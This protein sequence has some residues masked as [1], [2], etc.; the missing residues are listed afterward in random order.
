M[1]SYHK[2]STAG[3]LWRLASAAALAA[4]GSVAGAQTPTRPSD[5]TTTSLG[6]VVISATR[7]TTTLERVPL[8]ATVITQADIKKSPAQ[9]L[10]QL[11]RDIPGMNLP[12]A[13]FYTT[14]PTGQQTKLRGVTNSKVLVLVD[15]VP[16]HDPFYSTTQWFKVPLSSIERVEVIRG[17]S[18]SLWGN[19]A[20]A[21]V[22]NI[23]TRKPIDNGGQV[24]VNYQS[25]STTNAAGSKNF[26]F[27]NGFAIRASG[28]LLK[29]DGYQT[30]PET[31]LSAVPGKGAS[32]AKNANAQ[33]AAYY[34][35]GGSFNA[36]ARAGYHQQNEDVG[37]YR[38]GTNLQKS[39]DAAAGFT[40]FFSDKTRADVRAWG[41]YVSFDK[42][43][44]AGCYLASATNCNTTS[45]TAPLVQYANSHDD[46]PYRE[47]GASAIL[48]SSDVTGIV[49][50]VQ[51]GADFRTVGGEDRAITYNRPTTT[52]VASATINR[53]N[54]GRGTQRFVGGFGQLRATPIP[55]VEATLSLRYDYWTNTNGVSEMTKYTNAAAGQSAGGTLAD[56]HQSSLNPSAS[57]RVD[58]TD[59]LSFRGAAYRAF[60]A[61]G[62]NNLYRSFSS[63][64]SITIA[65]PNLSPE[66]LTGAEVGT[67][68]RT[69]GITLGGTVFQYN[70]NSLIA[71]YKIPNAAA[72]PSAV[73]AICGPTL[74]NCPATVNFNTNG[75]DAI[76]RG[77]EVVG[78]WRASPTITVDAGYTY[79][80]SHYT[81]TTTGDPIGV[82]LGAIP[83]NVGTF[84]VSWRP[85][86]RW[87]GFV[88]ARYNDAMFLDVNQTIH[89]AAFTLLNASTS[90][91]FNQRFEVY[92]SVTNLTDSKY[93]DNATTSAA[94]QTL[95]LG[96]AFTSGVRY[97][98]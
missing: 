78:T 28:D 3:F 32:S 51:V 77:A 44:G 10:D 89:Q 5:S 72:A 6:K 80:D 27:S 63:T 92:G 35:P 40:E 42:S 68:V 31:L 91:R 19:L 76:S 55:R 37:G 24:D 34:A 98:F 18:S 38:F 47:F 62:L 4:A 12:G 52:D 87:D 29:T 23:I 25:L 2:R 39:P 33:L 83:K 75:Q 60:R 17:G 59:H 64:T 49:P 54:F 15:G 84:G 88:G 53:T 97:R 90:Y 21:G 16:V 22:V 7:T 1:L 93:A 11:L 73:I 67:D 41:Q 36:F 65:N 66:T 46:N 94:G 70:T 81:S 14:D 43:N 74:A 26:V 48:S 30:T 57:V 50:S 20:V 85:T 96:R 79:T 69:G 56:S 61:P 86:P 58:A 95:G 71:A 45:T 9:T 82:Q 8:H 13:P